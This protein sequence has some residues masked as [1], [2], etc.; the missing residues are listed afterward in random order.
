[1]NRPPKPLAALLPVLVAAQ[2]VP[3]PPSPHLPAAPQAPVSEVVSATL[4]DAQLL[5]LIG[6]M[7]K[8]NH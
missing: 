1:M 4:C 8:E 7:V 6:R 3:R 2:A 5:D